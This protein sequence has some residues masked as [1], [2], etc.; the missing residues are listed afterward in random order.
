M[1]IGF[2]PAATDVPQ[3]VTSPARNW[4]AIGKRP[5]G[6]SALAGIVAIGVAAFAFVAVPALASGKPATYYACVG[7]TGTIKIVSRSAKCPAKQH[8]ISW[9][10]AG[11][12]GPRGKRGPAGPNGITS[13]YVDTVGGPVALSASPTTVATLSL[14]NGK[15]VITATAQAAGGSMPDTISCAFRSGSGSLIDFQSVTVAADS[16]QAISMSG[17][18]TAAGAQTLRCQDANS[19]SHIYYATISAVQVDRLTLTTG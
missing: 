10:S 6:L 16:E 9:N 11:P 17:A 4:R 12:T 8:K 1:R 19:S 18:T 2:K 7:K 13:G 3:G 5:R 14:P 15:F